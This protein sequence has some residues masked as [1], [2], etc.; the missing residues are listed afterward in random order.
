MIQPRSPS[1]RR[2]KRGA[3]ILNDPVLNKG[4]AFSHEERDVLGLRGL[5][6]ARVMTQDEQLA[7]ILPG[8]RSKPTPIDQYSYL[9][10]LHDR[11]V[12]LFYRLVIDH[13]EELM[14]VLYTPTVGQA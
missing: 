9:V 5:L 2:V 3:D 12:T 6:P 11:N 8:V 1:D 7:R 4:T 14:P 10:A 13:L